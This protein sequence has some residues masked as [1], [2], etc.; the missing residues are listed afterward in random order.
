MD[1]V[2]QPTEGRYQQVQKMLR[3][4]MGLRFDEAP[5]YDDFRRMIRDLFK[6]QR[7]EDAARQRE[8]E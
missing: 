1:F 3:L 4:C 8:E 2:S 6:G 5:P 7:D